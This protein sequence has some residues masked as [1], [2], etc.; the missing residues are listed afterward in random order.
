MPLRETNADPAEI[1]LNALIWI[2][3]DPGRADRLL[4]LT[5]LDP[6]DLRARVGDPAVLAA[7]L[8]F[9]E[10]HQPDLFACAD[11][12]DIRPEALVRARAALDPQ[13]ETE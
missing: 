7:V 13:R 6:D 11:A 5:G 1:G 12:L 8:G 4:A 2:L 10:Q 9:V 3:N